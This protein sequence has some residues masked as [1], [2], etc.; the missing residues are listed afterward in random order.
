VLG[1]VLGR[2]DLHLAGHDVCLVHDA[3]HAAVVIS[4]R[5]AVDDGDHGFLAQVLGK[6]TLAA[7]RK[8]H[9]K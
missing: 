6:K 7:D 9:L 8:K 5:V 1:D 2:E 3:A 4:V